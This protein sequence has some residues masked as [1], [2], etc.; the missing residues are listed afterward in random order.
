MVKIVSFLHFS[1]FFYHFLSHYPLKTA[2]FQ[3]ILLKTYILSEKFLE[4]SSFQ[5]QNV[6]VNA[7]RA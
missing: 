3:K 5:Y 2:N 6:R 4:N 1:H 7:L